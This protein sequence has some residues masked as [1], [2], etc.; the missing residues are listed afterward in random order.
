MWTPVA[1]GERALTPAV[2]VTAELVAD[3]VRLGG[4]THPLFTGAT[5]GPVPL[6]GQAVVLLMGGLVEQS[7][8]LDHAVALVELR[9]VRFA[10]MVHAGGSLRVAIEEKESTST[11]SGKSLTAYGWTAVDD[12]GATVAEAEAL[13]LMRGSGVDAGDDHQGEEAFG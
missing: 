13:M 1:S 8:L 2:E 9:R 5:G 3:L 10:K 4:Y 12:L 7:G 11:S 6:P